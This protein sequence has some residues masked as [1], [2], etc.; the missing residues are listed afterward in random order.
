MSEDI[1]FPTQFS[2][3]VKISQTAKGARIDVHVSA[4][5]RDDAI[6]EAIGMYKTTR[7]LLEN[8][9]EILAPMEVK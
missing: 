6:A 1:V 7:S 8:N 4:T 3:S 9:G 5:N 2:H